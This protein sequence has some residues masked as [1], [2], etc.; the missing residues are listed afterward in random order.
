[1]KLKNILP[2][3]AILLALAACQEKEIMMF[4]LQDTGIYFQEGGQTR[5]F[6]NIDRY[7]DSLAF[8]YS[9]APIT[10]T[11]TILTARL[12]TLGFVADYPRQVKL[13]VDTEKTTAVAGVHYDIDLDEA[14]IPAGESELLFPVT[15][16]RTADMLNKEFALVLK[17]EDNEHFKVFMVTQKNTNVYTDAGEM[18]DADRFKFTVSEIYTEP[19]YWSIFGNEYFG[20]W[21]VPKLKFLNSIA[22]WSMDDWQNAGTGKVLL[23]RFAVVAMTVRNELQALADA[24]TPMREADG[25]FMQMGANY[26]ADYSAHY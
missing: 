1:M 6:I 12:R 26:L 4:D 15:F 16:H 14:V 24:G 7:Y 8:S 20:A 10:T 22:G 21:S 18:I 17:V 11:D 25:S 23:G 3:F 9:V 13:S 2:G 19:W 5:L